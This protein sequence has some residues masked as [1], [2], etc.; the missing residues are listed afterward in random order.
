MK[1]VLFIA[2]MNLGIGFAAAVYSGRGPWSRY[3]RRHSQA[4]RQPKLSQPQTQ[5]FKS[6]PEIASDLESTEQEFQGLAQ[7]LS[8]EQSGQPPVT[9]LLAAARMAI[10]RFDTVAVE[11]VS[12]VDGEQATTGLKSLLT[13]LHTAVNDL[14]AATST[15]DIQKS[16]A[17]TALADGLIEGC[18]EARGMINAVQF[19]QQ[20]E[21][22]S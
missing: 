7:Q 10:E 20:P 22:A 19:S 5:T 12:R 9:E 11:G 21:I 1:L 6:A 4:A 2:L 8:A 17:L 18:R 15:A 13:R 3:A 14:E 16:S